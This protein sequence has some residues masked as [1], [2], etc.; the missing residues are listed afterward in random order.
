MR[1]RM[2]AESQIVPVPGRPG[3]VVTRYLLDA[4]RGRLAELGRQDNDG[5][6]RAER[7]RQIDDT[8]SAGGDRSGEIQKALAVHA[9]SPAFTNITAY[10]PSSRSTALGLAA[11]RWRMSSATSPRNT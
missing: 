6:I 2:L 3:V 4:H 10:A 8:H 7:E 11:R 5:K 9:D 1:A